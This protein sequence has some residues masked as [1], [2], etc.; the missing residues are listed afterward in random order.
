MDAPAQDVATCKDTIHTNLQLRIP[1]KGLGIFLT[2][3]ILEH[4]PQHYLKNEVRIDTF[5]VEAVVVTALEQ[6]V[7]AQLSVITKIICVYLCRPIC[8][9]SLVGLPDLSWDRYV[10]NQSQQNTMRI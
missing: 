8:F 4:S 10:V 2:R 7:S 5:R 6:D 1:C 9:C 3:G